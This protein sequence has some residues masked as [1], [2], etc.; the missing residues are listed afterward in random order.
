M[1]TL[2]GG[3]RE[4][5]TAEGAFTGDSIAIIECCFEVVRHVGTS[6]V[7]LEARTKTARL[8]FGTAAQSQLWTLSILLKDERIDDPDL[9]RR[10]IG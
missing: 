9:G 5:A 4:R 3:L 2:V 8:A 7:V 6:L 10:H 1:Q